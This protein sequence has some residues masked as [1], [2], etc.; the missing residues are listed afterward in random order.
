ML[1][2]LRS[3]SVH[4]KTHFKEIR[5]TI[6]FN[7]CAVKMLKKELNDQKAAKQ[8]GGLDFEKP[9]AGDMFMF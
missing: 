5:D 2:L 1:G 6:G 4:M 9:R 7:N 3:I 8:D